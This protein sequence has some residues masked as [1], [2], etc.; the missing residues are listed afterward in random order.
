MT[1]LDAD[2]CRWKKGDQLTP[3][4]LTTK[5][6]DDGK[7]ANISSEREIDPVGAK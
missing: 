3:D 6:K 1:G 5:K 2:L 7:E 4:G